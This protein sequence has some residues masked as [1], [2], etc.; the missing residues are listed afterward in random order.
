M[1][2]GSAVTYFGSTT[3]KHG[4][5]KFGIKDADRLRHMCVLGKAASTR[6]AFLAQVALQDVAR[7]IPVVL[8][9]LSGETSRLI[10]ERLDAEAL[11]RLVYLDAGDADYPYTFNPV[12]ELKKI[13]SMGEAVRPGSPQ[14]ARRLSELLADIYRLPVSA[15]TDFAAEELLKHHDATLVTLFLLI[16]DTKAREV[17]FEGNDDARAG[18]ESLLAEDPSIQQACEEHGKYV[19]KD[20]LVR[21]VFG[22]VE[23]KFS[24]IDT[25]DGAPIVLVDLSR[26]RIYPTRVTPIA[27]AWV[28]VS[29]AAGD[30]RGAPVSLLLFDCLRYLG[31]AAIERAFSDQNVAITVADASFGDGEKERRE[32]ALSRCGSVASFAANPADRPLIERAFYPYIDPEEL[33][34][35]G[36][37]ELLV[38]LTID[39]IRTKPFFGSLLPLPT[40]QNTS[41]QDEILAS[42]DKY[43]SPRL[44]V[45]EAI[46]SALRPKVAPDDDD[47]DDDE[48]DD[49]SFAS[50]FRSIFKPPAATG[51]P[52]QPPPAAMPPPSEAPSQPQ[53]PPAGEGEEKQSPQEIPE[54]RLKEMLYVHPRFA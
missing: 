26:I 17:F 33:S 52:P 13:P 47:E 20:T 51:A 10:I 41:Y 12:A 53:T 37:E 30:A 42:R 16:T 3:L 50:T 9:D 40:R 1:Q 6:E 8:I 32:K 4:Q 44:T 23:S 2:W 27:R 19:A 5:V 35:V 48:D 43:A 45:D 39:S 11:K 14:A 22:Q 25:P 21:N 28:E 24:L 18:F 54:D 31:E 46:R 29:R 34:D 38:A 49:D 15:F 7:N 36:E